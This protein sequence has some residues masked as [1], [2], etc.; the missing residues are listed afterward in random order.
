MLSH[1]EICEKAAR[2]GGAAVLQ[3]LGNVGVRLKSRADLVT[4]AD[5]AGEK[6]ITA[7]LHRALPG[8]EVL[9]EERT[10]SEGTDPMTLLDAEYCW[11]VDPLDGTTNFAHNVPHFCVSL[12]LIHRGELEVGCVFDPVRDELFSAIRGHGAR[13]NGHPIHTSRVARA[14]D[15]LA[16]IGLPPAVERDCP[17]LGAFLRAVPRFQ[18]LRRTGST[19]LN[20]AYVAMGRFDAAWSYSTHIWDMAA[21]ALLVRESGGVACS[22]CGGA[23]ELRSGRFLVS[24]TADLSREII[25]LLNSHNQ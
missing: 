6:I 23:L 20:L 2:L 24:A 8:H 19:A 15:A 14:A 18:A 7:T 12:A 9:G 5:L 16:A 1:I 21:G 4:D 17:D 11:V 25:S 3:R 22:P 13:L 10:H